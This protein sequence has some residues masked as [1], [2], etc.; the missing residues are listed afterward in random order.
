[1]NKGMNED[2]KNTELNK[3]KKTCQDMKVENNKELESLKN[4]KTDIKLGNFRKS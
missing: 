3:I 1:M 2:C 4:T